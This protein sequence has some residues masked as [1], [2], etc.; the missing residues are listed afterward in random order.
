MTSLIFDKRHFELSAGGVIMNI[1]VSFY[2][3]FAENLLKIS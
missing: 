3:R 2:L 1:T